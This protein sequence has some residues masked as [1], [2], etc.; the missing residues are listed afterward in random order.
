MTIFERFWDWVSAGF[1]HIFG[2][3]APAIKAWGEQFLTDEGV[4]IFTDAAIYGPQIWAGTIT[5]T[6]AFAKL[7][8]DLKAK[9]I[10]D[11]QQ[12]V[13]IT[14]NALRTHTNLAASQVTPAVT[15]TP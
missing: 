11:A 1:T 7:W 4:I 14:Y 5:I 15:P 13:E 8:E 12:G 2:A 6:D 3:N 10:T 9:G